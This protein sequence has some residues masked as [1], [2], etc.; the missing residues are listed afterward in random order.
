MTRVICHVL[1]FIS[2]LYWNSFKTWQRTRW[3]F[4]SWCI[5]PQNSK[6]CTLYFTW[7]YLCI[8]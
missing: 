7:L 3:I 2:R 8:F 1:F 5:K 4:M 6:R